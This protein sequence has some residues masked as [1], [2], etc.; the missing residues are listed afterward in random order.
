MRKAKIGS[1]ILE[2]E[3]FQ[4]FKGC[5][6]I[7]FQ[8][9][10]WRFSTNYSIIAWKVSWRLLRQFKYLFIYGCIHFSFIYFF[11][12][13]FICLF[14]APAHKSK[15]FYMLLFLKVTCAF[16]KVINHSVY[17]D[18]FLGRSKVI[19]TYTKKTFDSYL[20]MLKK[21]V[22]NIKEVS[23]HC[24]AQ[25]QVAYCFYKMAIWFKMIMLNK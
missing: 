7:S 2:R 13:W 21:K 11:L 1:V 17:Q 8:S 22:H 4:S 16:T 12:H 25:P 6:V 10:K 9:G 23:Y 15:L 20:T 14:C 3:I 24:N 19:L 5:G 18:T